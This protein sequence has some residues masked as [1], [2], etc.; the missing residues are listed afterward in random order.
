MEDQEWNSATDMAFTLLVFELGSSLVNYVAP[1]HTVGSKTPKDDDDDD[2]DDDDY[3]LEVVGLKF[4]SGIQALRTI[5][6]PI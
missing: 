2:D 3:S 5:S 4:Q 1:G 6:Q